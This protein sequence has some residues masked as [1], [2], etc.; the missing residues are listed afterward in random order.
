MVD[1]FQEHDDDG[2]GLVTV[3]EFAEPFDRVIVRFDRNGDGELTLDEVRHRGRDRDR[4]HGGDGDR[5]RG[6][7]QD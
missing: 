1:R 3:E 5:E 4:N 2:D 6:D 7:D